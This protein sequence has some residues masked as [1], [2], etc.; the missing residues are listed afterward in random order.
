MEGFT[1]IEND[2]LEKIVSLNLSG[3][4]HDCLLILLRK[5]NRFN[6]DSDGIS[7]TQFQTLTNRSRPTICKALKKLKLVNICL[8]VKSGKSSKTFSR[9]AINKNIESWKLVKK[10]LL[11][12]KKKQTSKENDTQ[13]VKKSRH[14]KETITKESIQKKEKPYSKKSTLLKEELHLE[15]YEYFGHKLSVSVVR[16]ECEKA[17]DWLDSKGKT[18]VDYRAFMRNWL[19]KTIKDQPEIVNQLADI[20]LYNP[21]DYE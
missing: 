4:E 5:T 8:L 1:K 2:I 20:P 10:P 3:T 19:R 6:K 17:L 12:K 9:Y 21:K 14:T 15:L 18:Q 11:V 7:L 13:L 16:E